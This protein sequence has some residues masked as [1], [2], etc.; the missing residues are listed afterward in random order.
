MKLFKNKKGINDISIISVITSIFLLTAI[1]IPFV[2]A[3]FGTDSDTFN[4]EAFEQ[5]VK[6]DAES[7]TTLSAFGILITLMKLALFDVGNTLN[8]PFWLDIVYTLLAVIFITVVARN[9][10]IG[11]GA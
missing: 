6:K 4:T 1:I 9:I 11:G 10:W 7:V 8:L 3:E 2:N 5:N